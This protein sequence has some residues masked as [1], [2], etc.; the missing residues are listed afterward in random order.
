MKKIMLLLG[1][2][3]MMMTTIG[4]VSAIDI[5]TC[6]DFQDID[7]DVNA[8]Y[9]LVND[10]DCSDTINWNNGYGFEEIG[11]GELTLADIDGHVLVKGVLQNE[12]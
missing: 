6:Q 11:D 5:S 2:M 12:N 1:I 9:D 3:I 8:S 10:I 7:N 4:I